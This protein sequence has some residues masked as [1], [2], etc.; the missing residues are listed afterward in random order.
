M[1]GLWATASIGAAKSHRHFDILRNAMNEKSLQKQGIQN[2]KLAKGTTKFT[3]RLRGDNIFCFF[4]K[5]L[6]RCT[7]VDMTKKSTSFRDSSQ[8]DEREISSKK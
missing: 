4:I 7:M 2:T 3:K 5:Y 8:R 1:L 6:P